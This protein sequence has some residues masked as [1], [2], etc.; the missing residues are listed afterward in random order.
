[1]Q[2]QR[3]R[4]AVDVLTRC[5]CHSISASPE[6]SQRAISALTVLVPE[7][8]CA[9]AAVLQASELAPL[10]GSV[11]QLVLRES[12]VH[13]AVLAALA[14][15]LPHTRCLDLIH[16]WVRLQRVWRHVLWQL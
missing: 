10:G 13:G 4:D 5:S 12:P 6:S 8:L 1:M 9:D 15:A 2:V 16:C 7:G 11:I 14:D 3:L